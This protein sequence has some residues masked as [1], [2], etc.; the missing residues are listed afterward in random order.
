VD[1]S[2]RPSSTLVVDALGVVVLALVIAVTAHSRLAGVQTR[3][4]ILWTSGEKDV[5]A[6][7]AD[8]C[9]EITQP[10]GDVGRVRAQLSRMVGDVQKS[11]RHVSVHR[12]DALSDMGGRL[13]F[14]AAIID[15]RAD[16][17]GCQLD[18]CAR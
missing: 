17:P 5:V 3:Y 8:C 18:P 4:R 15:D 2:L 1:L 13:P 6:V 9:G 16:G 12:C 14:S 11:L 10:H 7:F